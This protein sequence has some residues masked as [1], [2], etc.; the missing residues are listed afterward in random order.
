MS[1]IFSRN[2]IDKISSQNY[3]KM[4]FGAL[5]VMLFVGAPSAHAADREIC[6]PGNGV[7]GSFNGTWYSYYEG[8]T[9][10]D[11]SNRDVCMKIFNSRSKRFRITWDQNKTWREDVIGG[12]G[13]SR[14]SDKRKIGYNIGLLKSNSSDNPRTIAGLY[15]WTCGSSNKSK[16]PKT[17][18]QEYYV[19]DTWVGNDTFVPWDENRGRDG[20]PAKPLRKNGR[21]VIVSANGGRY[22][23]YKVRRNGAQFCGDGTP[24]SFDQFWSVRTS[25]LSLGK[26][27]AIDFGRHDSVWDN[28]GFKSARVRNG[29]Q[30]L[31]GEAFGHRNFR[32]KGVVD[33]T[34]WSRR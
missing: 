27:R 24:R 12:V 7:T 14:G 16:Y 26:N 32:H 9:Q 17:A 18:A 6:N 4:F 5:S 25:K 21:D 22:K 2:I 8:S 31:F 15:G 23:V 13:W 28:H 3:K 11:V 29:Y 1:H 33:G 19:V 10:R 34:V 20:A 30:I